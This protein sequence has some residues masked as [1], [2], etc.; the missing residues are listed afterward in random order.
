MLEP[1][2]AEAEFASAAERLS[3]LWQEFEELPY[4]RVRDK[5]VDLLQ[6]VDAVHRQPLE[7]VVSI[8]KEGGHPE[9]LDQLA[10]DPIVR[11]LML[12]YDLIPCD[13][14]TWVDAA[15]F[16]FQDYARA[17]GGAIEVENVADGM[18]TLRISG[19]CLA[20]SRSTNSLS[21]SIEETLRREFPAFRSL[22]IC[23]AESEHV[24]S[25]TG[26]ESWD[27]RCSLDAS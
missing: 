2:S 24:M 23:E 27:L 22:Q 14:R 4:P 17:H 18:V 11:Q 5:A 3:A 1:R 9:L 13:D 19:A 25:A 12:M 21:R 8:L 15:L 6:A 10:E 7:R 26:L 16:T 20:C